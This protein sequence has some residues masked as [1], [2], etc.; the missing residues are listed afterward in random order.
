MIQTTATNINDLWT[1]HMLLA[2][3]E[4]SP[5]AIGIHS[6]LI[7]P[8]EYEWFANTFYHGNIIGLKSE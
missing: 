8:C 5:A 6:C 7:R 4:I 1:S 3:N 2:S